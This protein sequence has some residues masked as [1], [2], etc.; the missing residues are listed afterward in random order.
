MIKVRDL[1]KVYVVKE[2]K[3]FLKKSK[4]H[5]AAVDKLSFNIK[6]GEITGLLGIN[7]AGKTTTVKMLSTLLEPTEGDISY[8]GKYLKKNEKLIKRKVNMIAGG[9]RMIYWRLTAK[10]NLRYFGSMYG[11]HGKELQ[12]RMEYLLEL[13]G[14]Q[15]KADI[16]VEKFSKGMKQR[17]Q[18]ARGL[19]NDPDYIFLDE[20]TLGLD[21]QIAKEMREFFVRL[22][23]EDNKGILLTTHYMKEVEELCRYIYILNEGKLLREGT[24]KDITKL[25]TAKDSKLENVLLKMAQ[26]VN[27][28][29]DVI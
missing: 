18:I 13:V 27:K 10:E 20:P 19:I 29:R 1:T 23:K 3:G 8:D 2:K 26:D 22:V 4:K 21:V 7:G 28:Q 12:E 14:L 5:L 15:D 24:V 17:L 6:K 16:P 25:S 11:L 9:E